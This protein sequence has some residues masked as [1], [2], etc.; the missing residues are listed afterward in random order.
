MIEWLKRFCEV[1]HKFNMQPWTEYI[2]ARFT[3][4]INWCIENDSPLPNDGLVEFCLNWAFAKLL[5]R[6]ALIYCTSS[7]VPKNLN[8][9]LQTKTKNWSS[10]INIITESMSVKLGY[11]LKH[12]IQ[13]SFLGGQ[14]WYCTSL[15]HSQCTTYISKLERIS[16]LIL[17]LQS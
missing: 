6:S 3:N 1:G 12:G 10:L 16:Q 15:G 9:S 11:G 2:E 7:Q 14:S 17:F 4:S 13:N 8:T 5:K